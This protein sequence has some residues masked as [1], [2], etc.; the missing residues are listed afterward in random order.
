MTYPVTFS[1]AYLD[2]Q[3]ICWT[4][5]PVVFRDEYHYSCLEDDY[6]RDIFPDV[7]D[8]IVQHVCPSVDEVEE[9]ETLSFE[10]DPDYKFEIGYESVIVA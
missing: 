8:W 10:I 5:V 4:K 1:V 9:C 6:F 7:L 3:K 2:Y